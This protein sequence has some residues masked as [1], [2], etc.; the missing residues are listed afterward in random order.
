[1]PDAG[2]GDIG[3]ADVWLGH[4]QALLGEPCSEL[5]WGAHSVM[6]DRGVDLDAADLM[7]VGRPA[8]PVVLDVQH[9]DALLGGDARTQLFVPR[10]SRSGGDRAA[11]ASSRSAR[12]G[13]RALR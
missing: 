5:A 7:R 12:T 9:R 4:W 11:T 10:G 3:L 8:A 2:S 1:M 13:Q 6:K